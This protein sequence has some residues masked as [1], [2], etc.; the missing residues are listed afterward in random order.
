MTVSPWIHEGCA[1]H[2]PLADTVCVYVFSDRSVV[3]T[4]E[5]G[6]KRPNGE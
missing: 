1:I 6:K 2:P 5:Y 3:D 4:Y